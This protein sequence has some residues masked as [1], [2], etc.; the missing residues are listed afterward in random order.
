M[1][2]QQ[3]KVAI[4]VHTMNEAIAFYEAS[5]WLVADVHGNR[6]YDLVCTNGDE[7]LHVEVKGTTT[8][9]AEVILTPNEV[10]HAREYGRVALFVVSGINLIRDDGEVTSSGGTICIHDPWQID[11]GALAPVGYRHQVPPGADC[12]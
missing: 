7:E 12:F 9:G 8:D 4:E 1:L 6:P 5:G 2:D 10:A 11:S 3:A